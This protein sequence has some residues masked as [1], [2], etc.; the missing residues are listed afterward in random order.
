MKIILITFLF[1]SQCNCEITPGNTKQYDAPFYYTT[2]NSLN[3]HLIDAQYVSSTSNNKNIEYPKYGI[4]YKPQHI[5]DATTSC[6]NSGSD[7]VE[8]SKEAS[9]KIRMRYTYPNSK[10]T[11]Y[12]YKIGV[13]VPSNQD[14]VTVHMGGIDIEC[15]VVPPS[16]ILIR[17]K[18]KDD[19]NDNR[20]ELT[21]NTDATNSN[22][23]WININ[24]TNDFDLTTNN[25]IIFNYV[26]TAKFGDPDKLTFSGSDVCS[27][28]GNNKCIEGYFCNGDKCSKCHE[29]CN[30][31]YASFLNS[32]SKCKIISDIQ[33]NN[34]ECEVNYIDMSNFNNIIINITPPK[35]QRVTLGVWMFVPYVY[36][37]SS[38]Q[39]ELEDFL[40]ISLSEYSTVNNKLNFECKSYSGSILSVLDDADSSGRWTYVECGMSVFHRKFFIRVAD[41]KHRDPEPFE[42]EMDLENNALTIGDN[43]DTYFT[44]YYGSDDTIQLTITRARIYLR[45]I[46]VFS[47]YMPRNIKYY[48]YDLTSISTKLHIKELIF[49]LPLN[50]LYLPYLSPYVI[51]INHS[52]NHKQIKIYLDKRNGIYTPARNLQRLILLEANKIY[53]TELTHKNLPTRNSNSLRDVNEN[54]FKCNNNE[55]IA[56]V[57]PDET[58]K[59]VCL[60]GCPSGSSVL[61]LNNGEHNFCN[62]QCNATNMLT[63]CGDKKFPTKCEEGY[64]NFYYKCLPDNRKYYLF[65]SRM[66]KS[67][68]INIQFTKNKLYRSYFI[69]LWYYRYQYSG[70]DTGV[71]EDKNYIFY[72]NTARLYIGGYGTTYYAEVKDNGAKNITKKV[73]TTQWNKFV[74]NCVFEKDT[75]KVEFIINNNFN[76][77]STIV[78][79][80]IRTNLDL[81][82]IVFV[83]DQPNYRDDSGDDT[84]KWAHGYYRNLR[85]WDGTKAQPSVTVNYDSLY[86]SSALVKGVILSLELSATSMENNKFQDTRKA[87]LPSGISSDYIIEDVEAVSNVEIINYSASFD[88]SPQCGNS[89][90]T[91]CVH[92]WN[93][94]RCYKCEDGYKVIDSKCVSA[95]SS[96]SSGGSG[97]SG[98]STTGGQLKVY[99]NPN[100]SNR[101]LQTKKL[102]AFRRGTICIW[103]KPYGLITNSGK[104]FSIGDKITFFYE[105]EQSDIYFGL[106]IRYSIS[107]NSFTIV[108]YI[109]NFRDNLGKW[110]FMSFA[111]WTGDS[112]L[113]SYFPPLMNFE[114]N[115]ESYDILLNPIPD[116]I[117]I[118]YFTLYEE[119]YGLIGG[120]YFFNE[121]IIGG[122]AYHKFQRAG[123]T[124]S[125]LT[126]YKTLFHPETDNCLIPND[127]TD[128]TVTYECMD[129]NDPV[130]DINKNITEYQKYYLF[131]NDGENKEAEC[132]PLCNE[133]FGE[134]EDKCAC[135]LSDELKRNMII[136]R[137]NKNYCQ[138]LEYFNFG[139]CNDFS[140]SLTQ[141]KAPPQNQ[142]TMHVWV[143]VSDYIPLNFKG[144][145]IIWE[146]HNA[147]S[148]SLDTNRYYFEC[149]PK[150]SD[151]S[152]MHKVPFETQKWN[153]LS[154]SI[155]W[156]NKEYLLQTLTDKENAGVPLDPPTELSSRSYHLHIRDKNISIEWG[157]LLI[158][159]IRL[160][161]EYLTDSL[162]MSRVDIQHPE[163]F[164]TLIHLFSPTYDTSHEIV[165]A[166]STSNNATLTCNVNLGV[167][168]VKETFAEQLALCGDD[169]K[170]YQEQPEKCV[171][172]LNI[173]NLAAA[174]TNVNANNEVFRINEI[175]PSYTGSYTMAFWIFIDNASKLTSIDF[176]FQDH[177]MIK[178]QKGV[179][180]LDAYCYPQMH[181]KQYTYNVGEIPLIPH[182]GEWHWMMCAV[183]HY[184]EKFYLNGNYFQL[185]P[186]ALYNGIVND[187][188]YRYFFTNASL[189]YFTINIQYGNTAKVYFRTMYLFNDFI[190]YKYNIQNTDLIKV[191]KKLFNELLF[192]IN[193]DQII[194]QPSQPWTGLAKLKY[195]TYYKNEDDKT[196]STL[197]LQF[198]ENVSYSLATNF[199]YVPICGINEKVNSKGYCE[200]VNTCVLNQVHAKLGCTDEKTPIICEN[201]YYMNVNSVTNVNTCEVGCNE[202]TLRLPGLSGVHLENAICSS[203]CPDNSKGTCPNKSKVELSA[204][205]NYYVCGTGYSRINYKCVPNEQESKSAFYYSK[206]YNLPNIELNIANSGCT[207]YNKNYIFE[208]WVMLDQVNFPQCSTNIDMVSGTQRYYVLY[209][210]PHTIYYSDDN[211]FYYEY[212]N[213]GVIREIVFHKYEWNR[214]AIIIDV[215][216]T[217]ITLYNNYKEVFTFL[218]SPT[219]PSP[220]SGVA[221]INFC[222]SFNTASTNCYNTQTNSD[223]YS[224]YYKNFRI[225]DALTAN[226]NIVN[227]FG[228]GLFTKP[229]TDLVR[230]W[231]FTVTYID[232][233]EFK[234]GISSST[235]NLKFVITS[236]VS[237]SSGIDEVILYNYSTMFDWGETKLGEYITL[238]DPDTK[239]VTSSACN[240]T[241]SRCTG[242]DGDKC[243][244][245]KD[246]YVLYGT[247]CHPISNYFLKLPLTSGN[248]LDLVSKK[249]DG[250][251]DLATQK[252]LTLSFFI[253]FFGNV[254][255]AVSRNPEI[256]SLSSTLKLLYNTTES[257]APFL[258]LAAG[259]TCFFKDFE[260]KTYIGKWTPIIIVDYISGSNSN[261]YP[262]ILT[263]SVNNKDLQL[264]E[265]IPPDG[266]PI[267]QLTFGSEI[268]ALVGDLRVYSKAIQGAYG[269]IMAGISRD[270][271]DLAHNIPMYGETKNGCMRETDLTVAGAMDFVECVGDYNI[272]LD[273]T[274][275]CTDNSKYFNEITRKCE[276]C[277]SECETNCYGPDEWHCTCDLSEG[278]Y[279]LREKPDDDTNSD[280]PF[281]YC[282][283]IKYID[284]SNL[285][286][287]SF[288]R[289]ASS[290]TGESTLEFWVYIHQYVDN[291]SNFKEINLDWNKHNRV[292]ILGTTVNCY[293]LVDITDYTKFSSP[294]VGTITFDAWNYVQCGTDL[295]QGETFV[296]TTHSPINPT[297]INLSITRSLT[298]TFLIYSNVNSLNNYGFVFLRHIK[299]WQQYNKEQ[300]L[301][302]KVNLTT[303]GKIKNTSGDGTSV[304]PEGG[305]FPGLRALFEND[306]AEYKMLFEDKVTD[307]IIDI[308]RRSDYIGYNVVKFED[309]VVS[310]YED[311]ILV[312]DTCS[313]H[314]LPSCGIAGTDGCIACLQENEYLHPD[315]NLLKCV[316]DCGD[317]Y[318]PNVDIKSC[319]PCYKTCY[320]CVGGGEFDCINCKDDYYLVEE[321]H[322][323]VSEC[324][325]YGLVKKKETPHNNKC[326]EF[327]VIVKLINLDENVAI[328]KKTFNKIEVSIERPGATSNPDTVNLLHVWSF[329]EI[330]TI[331]ANDNNPELIL[332]PLGPFANNVLNRVEVLVNPDF[333]QHGFKYT[334]CLTLYTP[335]PDSL[336]LKYYYT[337]YINAPPYGGEL[338]ITPHNGLR[339]TT[340]FI[341]N[342]INWKD[343]NYTMQVLEYRFYYIEDA[344]TT[345]QA[346]ADWTTNSETQA[347]I[348]VNN[349]QTDQTKVI[350]Y[351]EAR[352]AYHDI[353]RAET[354]L[355]IVNDLSYGH[356]KLENALD[357]YE[358]PSDPTEQHILVRSKLLH[359]MAIDPYKQLQPSFKQSYYEPSLDQSE[360]M[361]NDPEC[362]VSYCNSFGKCLLIDTFISC[363][364]VSGYLGTN[365]QV[366]IN[367][368]NIL[369][370]KYIE[371][372]ELI[373]TKLI[374]EAEYVLSGGHRP[375]VSDTLLNA[376]GYLFEGVSLYYQDYSFFSTR[377]PQLFDVIVQYYEAR[378]ISEFFDFFIQLYEY[379]YEFL[380]RKVS[381]EKASMKNLMNSDERVID[382]PEESI[383]AYKEQFDMIFEQ[384]DNLMN[385]YIKHSSLTTLRRTNMDFIYNS[386]YVLMTRI[387]P[388]TTETFLFNERKSTYKTNI[389][390]KQ[391]LTHFFPSNDYDLL[392]VYIDYSPFPLLYDTALYINNTSPLISLRFFDI[393]TQSEIKLNCSYEHNASILIN[394]PFNSF[395]WLEDINAQKHLYDP[396]NYKG[397]HDIIF[398]DPIL[399]EDNGFISNDTVE[400]R[401]KKYHRKYN[402][403]CRYWNNDTQLF[404]TNYMEYMNL[405]SDSN[406]IVC[407]CPWGGR[408]TTYL[409][410]NN[411][412]YQTNSRFFYLYRQRI[413]NYYP[414]YIDNSAF[415]IWVLMMFVYLIF[416]VVFV[417]KDKKMLDNKEKIDFL[418]IEVVQNYFPYIDSSSEEMQQ[419]LKKINKKKNNNDEEYKKNFFVN[420]SEG[421]DNGVSGVSGG[422]SGGSNEKPIVLSSNVTL[423]KFYT[424]GKSNGGQ[425]HP[426]DSSLVDTKGQVPNTE[427]NRN[428]KNNFF[429]DDDVSNNDNNQNM[430]TTKFQ[431]ETV[432]EEHIIISELNNKSGESNE[433]TNNN[434]NSNSNNNNEIQFQTHETNK[435]N[436][437]KKNKNDNNNYISDVSFS[438]RQN[439]SQLEKKY[440]NDESLYSSQRFLHKPKEKDVSYSAGQSYGYIEQHLQNAPVFVNHEDSLIESERQPVK[441]LSEKEIL[442]EQERLK[443]EKEKQIKQQK[444]KEFQLSLKN[445]SLKSKEDY[446][447]L[448]TS[449]YDFY[450]RNIRERHKFFSIFKRITIFHPRWKKITLIYME[451]FILI[452][453]NTI[454]LTLD[455]SLIIW[456]FSPGLLLVAVI[457]ISITVM[458][459]YPLSLLFVVPYSNRDK[460]YILVTKGEELTVLREWK[461]LSCKMNCR[462]FVGMMIFIIL[463]IITF[464]FSFGFTAVWSVQRNTWIC[465]TLFCVLM[466]YTLCEIMMELIVAMFYAL[467]KKGKCCLCCGYCLNKARSKRVLWP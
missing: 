53:L 453:T 135:Y 463:M 439:T 409:I 179:D 10:T 97:G 393:A 82:Y 17:I 307:K 243:Y 175:E 33:N 99:K 133:C 293:P 447:L 434:S 288:D 3:H 88:R 384:I 44:N 76:N 422:V 355:Y 408:F 432:H 115:S 56:L 141:T 151:R 147:I 30:E 63:D 22:D 458:L 196:E 130:Y 7:L 150:E 136:H 296:R 294:R 118:D 125:G 436:P 330:K 397:S 169:G 438:G 128:V 209:T 261:V 364:C 457:S 140:I 184:D 139:S 162:A 26:L 149:Y 454:L 385:M 410:E 89:S 223:W 348:N 161:N 415:W 52:L 83:H 331:E 127:F 9:N 14:T 55:V 224:A 126:P 121:Y 334:F 325:D 279:W 300:I 341:F 230:F 103:V 308:T 327:D 214:I 402:I 351:C 221:S 263:L 102:N 201:G 391:C 321:T 19:P 461:R 428:V 23:L 283:K 289:I 382:L 366:D 319:R 398:S 172:F 455:E 449:V 444:Q 24:L 138:T 451:I 238:I 256:M 338:V 170:Y 192:A 407:A 11:V 108:S 166:I 73:D 66:F 285:N 344:T 275:K 412:T 71:N 171:T 465:L 424:G 361:L 376:I 181:M 107:A 417:N 229:T 101:S 295:V 5:P 242:S 333:F 431:F 400:M 291:S 98:G 423:S 182:S 95:S 360:I 67:G 195:Y 374:E 252:A 120:V 39:I 59:Y 390:F 78:F 50:K 152:S 290:A 446:A 420:E 249:E 174:N 1:I 452:L 357:T 305:N 4:T 110:T 104:L 86:D 47:E 137:G 211:K 276:A 306:F 240:V 165:D 207:V 239:G 266:L 185:K 260:F 299:L 12:Y 259:Q 353:S 116:N 213:S 310:C 352:D 297:D 234:E 373:I 395:T 427:R 267:T 146:Y 359:S 363:G 368:Y 466:I 316:T 336:T 75:Y 301:T 61:P 241:C 20:I 462:T 87:N 375:H 430:R 36:E 383:E 435:A 48:H 216:T 313:P 337:F 365:C 231:P 70:A 164:E 326:V 389:N 217:N 318:Y 322:A 442:K 77:G 219:I 212:A 183:S 134:G 202:N 416:V 157:Y 274:N 386:M 328:D 81:N 27:R 356:Y 304:K 270:R 200:A 277:N 34:S 159:Q 292:Q 173:N 38:F 265:E 396:L 232:N 160:W 404:D 49:S 188:P 414:N 273:P 62:I 303:Y 163:L 177:L 311:Q 93:N 302:Q 21:C 251:F 257:N 129:D 154:C 377:L 401:L 437:P 131:I 460:L 105:S 264:V 220:L 58:G 317:E 441:Q 450:C 298:D 203:A 421:S 109:D 429:N 74:I 346:I 35:T 31:C 225:W 189:K 96:S 112:T 199:K 268:A 425:L 342:C 37:L 464:Y 190:P 45:N 94:T 227:A 79:P 287:I 315:P 245:C 122:V 323:C 445:A 124:P 72:S 419:M 144:F 345:E 269:R 340:A 80:N 433:N 459:M 369:T 392:M 69:E 250:S 13:C 332:N 85:V 272:F 8:I 413:F 448:G 193:F 16:H 335:A 198:N 218:T 119:L 380:I 191:D 405:T 158:R 155:N 286:K 233:N 180:G 156:D 145:E 388:S 18:I 176:V 440:T 197:E 258:S 350:V 178:L 399:I 2:G 40:T 244:A 371:L 324:Q 208:F 426:V 215:A 106:T 222:S 236:T 456:P 349:F 467:R 378:T 65:Y 379:Y 64:T 329:D 43:F 28:S 68:N 248:Q 406:Y 235:C 186:D 278:K 142:F 143:W 117:I 132:S 339:N 237:Y 367:G 210:D 354:E 168:A 167:N 228:S 343:D 42:Q 394:F 280:K 54:Y 6:S 100:K 320:S 153:F 246:K 370:S 92:C 60:N 51:G 443:K 204:M 15:K 32:C 254:N 25:K 29:L 312:G 411:I 358:I 282:E 187:Y 148:I 381:G 247:E 46:W 372:F 347:V 403:T 262:N 111:Y 309:P 91:H 114:I 205:K 418:K 362:T 226:I 57:P 41:R 284:F 84:I 255:G 123:T 90:L 281:T 314:S 253:K 271:I 206:C 194:K 387:E 113:L